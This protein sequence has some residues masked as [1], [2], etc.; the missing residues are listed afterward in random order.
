MSASKATTTGGA[1]AGG[2]LA[3]R[4]QLEREWANLKERIAAIRLEKDEIN[5]RIA[6]ADEAARARAVAAARAGEQV[7]TSAGDEAREHLATHLEA[8]ARDGAALVQAE[9]AIP[10]ELDELHREHWEEFAQEAERLDEAA[11]LALADLEA[12]YRTARDA[13]QAAS[14]AWREATG[15]LEPALHGGPR[16]VRRVPDWPLPTPDEAFSEEHRPRPPG[17]LTQAER[18]TVAKREPGP[19]R[20]V[21]S[22]DVRTYVAEHLEVLALEPFDEYGFTR[23]VP[24][25]MR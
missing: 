4:R 3:R 21:T 1:G 20:D 5:A 22:G 19:Y 16:D 24:E 7:D 10:R 6:E 14:G 12:H 8:N 13:W 9:R 15:H 11:V 25:E 2:A 17:Y 23:Y 18:E